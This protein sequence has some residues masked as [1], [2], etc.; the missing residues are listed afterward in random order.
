MVNIF[1]LI[2]IPR[3]YFADKIYIKNNNLECDLYDY[4]YNNLHHE[5]YDTFKLNKLNS[6]L[7]DALTNNANE[8]HI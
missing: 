7:Q 5:N 8:E 4:L 3:H 6:E 1:N 2:E